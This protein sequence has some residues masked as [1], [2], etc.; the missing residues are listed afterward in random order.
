MLTEKAYHSGFY[1]PSALSDASEMVKR[2]EAC[3]LH[4]KQIYQPAQEL[5]TISLTWP[6]AVWGLDI[7]GSFPRAQEGYRYLYIAIDK[8]NKWGRWSWCAPFPP[9][10]RQ[11]HPWAGV[12]LQC[13]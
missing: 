8:F 10:R 12:P 4:A 6:F 9:G 5:Q 13:A 1:W 2:C 11:V 3:Q 7:L